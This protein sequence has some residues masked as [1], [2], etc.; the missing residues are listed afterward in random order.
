MPGYCGKDNKKRPEKLDEKKLAEQGLLL[1]ME[2]IFF[3]LS[4]WVWEYHNSEHSS[5]GMTPLQMYE[6]TMKGRT[7]LPDPRAMD[8]ALMDMGTATVT[9]SG[10]QRLVPEPQVW[11]RMKM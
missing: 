4:H 10:I 11:Y 6:Q 5:L 1:T 9:S 7:E 3:L 8:I 2:E